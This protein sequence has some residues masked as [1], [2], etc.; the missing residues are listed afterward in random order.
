MVSIHSL[1]VC[2]NAG[3][4]ARWA[5]GGRDAACLSEIA[6]SVWLPSRI[7]LSETAEFRDVPI[8]RMRWR[9][10]GVRVKHLKG[11]ETTVAPRPRSRYTERDIDLQL[12]STPPSKPIRT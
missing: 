12:S 8:H 10:S 11:P 7:C 5:K 2:C 4:V 6:V 1:H 9:S 3:H